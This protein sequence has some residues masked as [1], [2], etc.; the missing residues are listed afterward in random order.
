MEFKINEYTV[1][2]SIEFNFEELKQA[3]QERVAFYSDLVYTESEIREAK[4][5]RARLRKVIEAIDSQRKQVKADLLAPYTALEAKLDEIKALVQEPIAMIDSQIKAYEESQKETKGENIKQEWAKRGDL[6][7][8]FVIWNAKW[9]NATYSMKKIE[10]E[11]D[12][13]ILKFEEGLTTLEKLDEYTFEAVEVFKNTLDLG[14]A[15]VMVNE[16]KEK[17]KR[18]AEY[19]AKRQE[20][21]QEQQA[22]IDARRQERVSHET[23]SWPE[24]SKRSWIRFEAFLSVEEAMELNRYFK[25]RGIEIRKGE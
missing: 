6:F 9:L 21:Q 23:E 4:A 11:M 8:L 15:M 25:E 7:D 24:E 13:A 10:D 18:K 17:A 20:L 2:E 5:D 12:E 14:A 19:E 22:E 1:P 3:V 16:L